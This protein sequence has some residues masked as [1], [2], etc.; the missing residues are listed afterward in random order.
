MDLT[1]LQW[2]AFNAIDQESCSYHF[3]ADHHDVFIYGSGMLNLS[4]P[5]EFNSNWFMFEK[6][7]QKWFHLPEFTGT[8]IRGG[9][10]F[11]F[12]SELIKCSGLNQDLLRINDVWEL[13]LPDFENN[14]TEF[15]YLRNKK[16]L[17]ISHGKTAALNIYLHHLSGREIKNWFITQPD[18]EIRINL[19]GTAKGLYLVTLIDHNIKSTFKL[20]IF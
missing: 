2:S 15:L 13:K 16:E 6:K 19:S 11:Y 5:Y 10:L 12:E 3:Q 7:N 20:L 4:S 17:I 9:G 1:T 8:P 14:A 18:D